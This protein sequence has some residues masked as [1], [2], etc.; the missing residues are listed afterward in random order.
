MRSDWKRIII[1]TGAICLLVSISCG[2]RKRWFDYPSL[3]DSDKSRL[4]RI[5]IETILE[6]N[7]K[8]FS[9]VLGDSIVYVSGYDLKQ[10]HLPHIR[11][12]RLVLLNEKLR[13]SKVS[14]VETFKYLAIKLCPDYEKARVYLEIDIAYPEELAKWM[15]FGKHIRNA[16]EFKF[17]KEAKKWILDDVQFVEYEIIY[18]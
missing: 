8:F 2:T 7:K 14:E 13:T 16:L 12:I 9:E 15:Y 17:H 18:N 5:T 1:F 6:S 4:I 3:S 11:G 10:E